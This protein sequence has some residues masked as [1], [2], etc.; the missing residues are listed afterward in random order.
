MK[1]SLSSFLVSVLD[2][3]GKLW[4]TVHHPGIA[5][6]PFTF[7]FFPL[8]EP[9]TFAFCS[10]ACF[11]AETA[12]GC[13]ALLC[14]CGRSG[15]SQRRLSIPRAVELLCG[16]PDQSLDVFQNLSILNMFTIVTGMW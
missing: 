5:R 11:E 6:R 1:R 10:E 3:A 4:G 15:Q 13:F 16:T 8:L 12:E 2:S 9:L 7:A 14:S